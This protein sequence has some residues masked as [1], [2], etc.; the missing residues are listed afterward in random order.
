MFCGVDWGRL[1]IKRKDC[2]RAKA[3][4]TAVA[5]VA[6]PHPRQCQNREC[7]RLACIAICQIWQPLACGNCLPVQ[8]EETASAALP[9]CGV[10]LL[11]RTLNGHGSLIP[12]Q[13]S[14]CAA[15]QMQGSP[16]GLSQNFASTAGWLTWTC[17]RLSPL[18]FQVLFEPRCPVPLF[19]NNTV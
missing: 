18:V 1:Q 11:I 9:F 7:W 14:D 10:F 3:K 8:S 19:D 6:Q 13:S 15:G 17:T 16:E 12:V 4:R 2:R 5:P